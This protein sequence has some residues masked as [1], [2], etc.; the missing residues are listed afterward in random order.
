MTRRMSSTSWLN[1]KQAILIGWRL[2]RP[3][4]PGTGRLPARERRDNDPEFV[5]VAQTRAD[6]AIAVIRR[7]VD[8]RD[9]QSSTSDGERRLLGVLSLYCLLLSLSNTP[10][11]EL[12]APTTVRVRASADQKPPPDCSPS[13]T[14]RHPGRG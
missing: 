2:T 13:A 14:S 7:L 9:G 10:V 6:E 11:G 5:A 1:P 12:M 3:R 8:G 4:D